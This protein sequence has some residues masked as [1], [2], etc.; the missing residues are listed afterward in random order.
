MGEFEDNA[1]PGSLVKPFTDKRM[2]EDHDRE[3]R[4]LSAIA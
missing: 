1:S 3:G 2:E 4:H